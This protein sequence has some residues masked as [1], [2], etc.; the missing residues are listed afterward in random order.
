M[1]T[2]LGAC[3]LAKRDGLSLQNLARSTSVGIAASVSHVPDFEIGLM[4]CALGTLTKEGLIF[5][6]GNSSWI[7]SLAPVRED[8]AQR[9]LISRAYRSKTMGF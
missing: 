2:G 7:A 6:K 1:K 5:L 4:C 8:F 3:L 9:L